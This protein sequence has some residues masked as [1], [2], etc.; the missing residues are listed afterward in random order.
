MD[1]ILEPLRLDAKSPNLAAT[2]FLAIGKVEREDLP[3]VSNPPKHF[4]HIPRPITPEDVQTAL[5]ELDRTTKRENEPELEIEN[6]C[7][8][9]IGSLTTPRQNMRASE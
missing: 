3:L 8:T 6:R 2:S 7:R 5:G 1:Q 4:L 9:S